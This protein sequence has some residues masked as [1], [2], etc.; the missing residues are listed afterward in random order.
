MPDSLMHPVQ[1]LP[2]ELLLDIFENCCGADGFDGRVNDAM[3]IGSVCSRWRY[4]ATGCSGLWSRFDLN[5]PGH[6]SEWA[7]STLD[8]QM[9]LVDLLLE[10]SGDHDLYL[11]L[12]LS[13]PEHPILVKLA[14]HASRWQELSLTIQGELPSGDHP[15][16]TFEALDLPVLESLKIYSD[17]SQVEAFP[18]DHLLPR[19]PK[20]CTFRA[21]IQGHTFFILQQ[22]FAAS[23]RDLT[24]EIKQVMSLRTLLSPYQNLKRLSLEENIAGNWLGVQ[25]NHILPCLEL[26]SIL[27]TRGVAHL[28]VSALTTPGLKEL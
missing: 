18:Y 8:P 19:V 15:F 24:Y 4:L 3:H 10:R 14:Q 12:S 5:L 23:I 26:L 17:D 2:N 1:R 6:S 21:R 9:P 16:P 22:S 7:G 13:L 20:V 28:V 27:Y 25:P 11:S